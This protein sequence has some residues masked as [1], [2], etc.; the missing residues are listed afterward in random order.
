MAESIKSNHL[1]IVYADELPPYQNKTIW[2]LLAAVFKE[3]NIEYY[4]IK[5]V[6][7]ITTGIVGLAFIIFTIIHALKFLAAAMH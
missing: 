6:L 7:I 1:R 4:I 3:H 2:K 5:A